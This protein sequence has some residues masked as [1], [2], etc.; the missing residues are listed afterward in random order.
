MT[1]E[2]ENVERAGWMPRFTIRTLMVICTV[3]AVASVIIGTAFRGQYWAWGV[4]IGLFSLVVTAL[5]HAAW[6]GF[7]WV[8][9]QVPE[10]RPVYFPTL[11]STPIAGATTAADDGSE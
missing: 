4:T 2:T 1:E 3:C 6:F 10:R 9:A 8:F 5:V 7:L 11:S